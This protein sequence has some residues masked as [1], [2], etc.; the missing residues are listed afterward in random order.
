MSSEAEAQLPISWHRTFSRPRGYLSP[1][2]KCVSSV[3]ELT[4]FASPRTS[5]SLSVWGFKD[6]PQVQ[7]V[8]G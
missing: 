4:Q 3:I 6:S 5:F 8:R 2:F 7:G 1:K